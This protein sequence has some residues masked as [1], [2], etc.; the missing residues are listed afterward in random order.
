MR[1]RHSWSSRATD[2][3]EED[4]IKIRFLGAA[5]QVTGSCY[6]IQAEGLRI[7]V[8]CGLFQERAYL[9]R[10]WDPFPVPPHQVD[11]LLLTHSH[12]DH[13]GLI[14]KLVKEGFSG[15]ILTTSASIDL[16]KIVLMDTARIQTEDAAFKKKRHK[17]EKRRGP[18]PEIPLYTI[19]DVAKSIPYLKKVSYNKRISLNGD[20][21]VCYHDAGH[22]L[23]SAMLELMIRENGRSRKIVFS[24]DIGQWDKPLVRDPSV[25][26]EADYIVMESTYGDRNHEKPG[27]VKQTLCS[28]I[29]ET[30]EA[31]GNIIIPTFAI[32]RAQELMYHLSRLVREKCIPRLM[33]FLDSPMAVDV[34]DVFLKHK[35]ILD[36]K[37]L[38]LFQEEEPPFRFPGLRFIRTPSASKAINSIKGSCIIMAGSGMC[39]GGRIKHHLVHNISRPESSVL[40]VG[41]Q[42][43]GTLGRLIVSGQDPVRIHGESHKVKARI[44][45]IFGFSAHADRRA[46]FRWLGSV[47]KPPRQVFVTHGEEQAALNLAKVIRNKMGWKASVPEYKEEFELD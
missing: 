20:V 15:S 17:K 42:A 18:H 31:G 35:D 32:E 26:Q 13:A 29:N 10:N 4:S 9:N 43:S 16:L 1:H 41:Y 6:F 21:T 3:N 5:R 39:T 34:T 19:K 7:L 24:G 12:L 23:G 44:E 28:L 11:Y 46:L 14:P 36:R 40:F 22:I 37:T 30:A 45:K 33:V 8:D 38:E 25:F 27:N 47:Q 2:K